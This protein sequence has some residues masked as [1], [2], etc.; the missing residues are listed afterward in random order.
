MAIFRRFAEIASR[1]YTVNLHKNEYE[2]MLKLYSPVF[3][4][5]FLRFSHLKMNF[6]KL[7]CA[8]IAQ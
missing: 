6:E 1:F 7:K 5:I 3:H 8:T 4:M 2:K